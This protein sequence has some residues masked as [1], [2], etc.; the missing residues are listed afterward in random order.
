MFGYV[1]I[2]NLE[3]S[4]NFH[5]T[6]LQFTVIKMFTVQKKLFFFLTPGYFLRAS[7]LQNSPYFC[8]SIQVR[9]SSQTKVLERARLKTACE[10]RALRARKTLSPRFTDFFTDFEKK[11]TDCFAVYLAS[12]ADF[13]RGSSRVPASRTSAEFLSLCSQTS[14]GVDIQIMGDPIG[15]VE[16][17]V[18]TSETHTYKLCRV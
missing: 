10:A 13:L 2:Y 15:A 16:V 17:K 4:F 6:F 3:V 5:L 7:R 9:A 18:L 14:A 1:L 11:K 12:H 8:I